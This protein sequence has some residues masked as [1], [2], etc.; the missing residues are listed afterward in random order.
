[1][2]GPIPSSLCPAQNLPRHCSHLRGNTSP[3]P[4]TGHPPSNPLFPYGRFGNRPPLPTY[5]FDYYHPHPP[6]VG[7]T[8]VVALPLSLSSRMRGPI[9]SSVTPLE[10]PSPVTDWGRNESPR[11]LPRHAAPTFHRDGSRRNHVPH[12]FFPQGQEPIPRT[13]PIIHSQLHSSRRG[14]SGTARPH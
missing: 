14:G 7:E 13:L 12:P 8:L 9:P 2:R 11:T 10:E 4:S 5:G 1:M 3:A 6:P